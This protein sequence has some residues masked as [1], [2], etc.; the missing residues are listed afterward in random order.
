MIQFGGYLVFATC[1]VF[2]F[3]RRSIVAAV[4]TIITAAAPMIMIPVVFSGEVD[5][6]VA[7][8]K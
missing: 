7:V 2:G 3:L 4:T 5:A 8:D 6:V 1:V